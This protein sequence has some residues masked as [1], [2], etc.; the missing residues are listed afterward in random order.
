MRVINLNGYIDEDV[1]YGDEIT[2]DMLHEQL[3]AEDEDH[4]QPVRIILNSYGGSC[5]AA[6]RMYDDV[7]AYPGNVHIII[8]GTAASAAAAAAINCVTPQRLT[9]TMLPLT[10]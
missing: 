8:S 9:G 7:R 10:R 2:P 1:W 6:V 5:N 4:Q 3:F